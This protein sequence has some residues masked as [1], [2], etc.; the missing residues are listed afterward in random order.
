MIV[1]ADDFGLAPGV[2]RAILTL[3]REHRLSAVSA[4]VC[5]PDTY[6]DFEQ[7]KILADSVDV[8][9]HLRYTSPHTGE[10]LTPKMLLKGET[11][12]PAFERHLTEETLQSLILFRHLMGRVPVFIDGHR[13][14][15]AFPVIA[16]SLKKVLERYPEFKP[17]YIRGYSELRNFSLT[18]LALQLLWK[19]SSRLLQPLQLSQTPS[20]LLLPVLLTSGMETKLRDQLAS[21][22]HRHDLLVVHPG[23]VDDT[24][25]SRDPIR[26]HRELCF[27]ALSS[28]DFSQALI[29]HG[30]VNRYVA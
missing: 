23:F 5:Y 6:Q 14:L 13:H 4:M 30:G 19:K 22:T 1:C 12:S 20:A 29:A 21:A 8:G 16:S 9:L 18:G 3:V 28:N 26:S 10:E 15:H 25:R 11:L 7:L 27:R 24:L 2:N 17:K